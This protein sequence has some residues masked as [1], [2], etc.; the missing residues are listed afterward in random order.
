MAEKR[1]T[2]RILIV[3]IHDEKCYGSIVK[4]GAYASSIKYQKYGID[5]EVFMDNEDFSI[6]DEIGFEYV[7]EN[8]D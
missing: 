2:Y 3:W 5:Y 6:M 8:D 4:E 1:E 7:E